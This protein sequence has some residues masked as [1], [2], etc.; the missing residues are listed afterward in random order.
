MEISDDTQVY[1][2]YAI[3][4]TV[5]VNK[6]ILKRNSMYVDIPNNRMRHTKN[7]LFLS[8]GFRVCR[9][10]PTFILFSYCLFYAHL[11]VFIGGVCVCV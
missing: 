10:K 2:K 9:Q 8:I 6:V 1:L 5:I 7:I 4:N 3:W 11:F